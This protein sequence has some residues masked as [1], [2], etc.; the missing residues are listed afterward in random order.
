MSEIRYVT[1][2]GPIT[3]TVQHDLADVMAY[4]ETLFQTPGLLQ[5]AQA[6]ALVKLCQSH[7]EKT[8]ERDFCVLVQE[9]TADGGHFGG[10]LDKA[11]LAFSIRQA[12]FGA[13][14]GDVIGLT[15]PQW[16]ALCE[17]L[18]KPSAGY[19]LEVIFQLVPHARAIL[20]APSTRPEPVAVSD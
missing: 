16:E 11:L 7:R 3:V 14:P 4:V 12:F 10:D 6:S 18:R 8:V 15:L 9:R 19:N 2:P 17:S 1:V 20:D 13:K 5:P